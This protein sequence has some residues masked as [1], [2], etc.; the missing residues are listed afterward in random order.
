MNTEP[1]LLSKLAGNQSVPKNNTQE[2][3]A[4]SDMEEQRNTEN[5]LNLNLNVGSTSSVQVLP[6]YVCLWFHSK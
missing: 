1:P 3:E 5:V 4:Y 6:V 2:Q